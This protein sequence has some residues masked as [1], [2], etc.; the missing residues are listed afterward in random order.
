MDRFWQKVRIPNDPYDCWEWTAST[1]YGYGVVGLGRRKDGTKQAHRVSYEY[2]YEFVPNGLEV[3]HACNN[4]KCVNPYHLYPGTRSDNMKQAWK[5]GTGM[6]PNR[7]KPGAWH[8][9]PYRRPH[10]WVA[11]LKVE[12]Q[13]LEEEMRKW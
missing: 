3:C 11:R 12:L 10:D 5:D 7:W 4:R 6:V 13:E 1:T 9:N 2:F 8:P